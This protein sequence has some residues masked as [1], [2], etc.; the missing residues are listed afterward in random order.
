MN[1]YRRAESRSV[2]RIVRFEEALGRSVN[3]RAVRR[4]IR[5]Y[6]RLFASTP[7]TIHD[8]VRRLAYSCNEAVRSIGSIRES[9]NLANEALRTSAISDKLSMYRR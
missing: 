5:A 7:K 9:L 6:K 8:S 2:K 1:K 3:Y 4:K